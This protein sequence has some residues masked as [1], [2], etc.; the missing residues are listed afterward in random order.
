VWPGA[1]VTYNKWVEKVRLR[2]KERKK[3][4]G[5]QEEVL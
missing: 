2:N 3:E 1:T 5:K 4:S